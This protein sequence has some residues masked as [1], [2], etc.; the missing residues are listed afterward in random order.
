MVGELVWDVQ[1]QMVIVVHI[2][3]A[4][5]IEFEETAEDHDCREVM[6]TCTFF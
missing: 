5:L 1:Y 4:A 6:T 2:L 3:A